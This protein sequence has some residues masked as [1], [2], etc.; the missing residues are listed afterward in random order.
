MKRFLIIVVTLIICWI[1]FL[2]CDCT[3]NSEEEIGKDIPAP[4]KNSIPEFELPPVEVVA[5]KS[6]YDYT[7]KE[8]DLLARLIYS[9]SGGESYETKLK[10]GSVV[11]NR[12]E[13]DKFPNTIH[14]VIYQE[15]QFSVTTYKL[16][17]VVMIDR[18]ANEESIKAAREILENGSVLPADVQVFYADYCKESWVN[19]REVYG[20]SDSTVF[21]YIYPKKGE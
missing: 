19:S 16:N 14:D 5:K 13:S 1:G 21:A 10:V 15:K 6:Y 3:Y 9:E 7:E 11:M 20:V 4:A 18:P 17:G 8:L 2:S 12:V